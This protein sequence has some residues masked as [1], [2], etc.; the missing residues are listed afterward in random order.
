MGARYIITLTPEEKGELT[1]L[2]KTR[3]SDSRTALFARAL[4]L[5]EKPS[6]GPG[7]LSKDVCEALGFGEA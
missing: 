5:S 7:W 2:T 3:K 4:I 6:E 1:K